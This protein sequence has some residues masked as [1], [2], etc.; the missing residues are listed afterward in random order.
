MNPAE[1]A[2]ALRAVQDRPE[3]VKI[4]RVRFWI[5]RADEMSK[6]AAQVRVNMMRWRQLEDKFPEDQ[7]L[8][9][10][11]YR[12]ARSDGYQFAWAME[13]EVQRLLSSLSKGGDE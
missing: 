1:N 9:A 11:A 6:L 8:R 7:E 12:R 10:V 3:N 13:S 4:G 5:Q 2:R